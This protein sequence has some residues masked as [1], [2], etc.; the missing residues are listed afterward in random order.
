LLLVVWLVKV[1]VVM[2]AVMEL[3]TVLALM[4]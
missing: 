2:L 3:V 1:L 4:L